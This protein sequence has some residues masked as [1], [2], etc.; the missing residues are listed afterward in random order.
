[1][2]RVAAIEEPD[3]SATVPP[4]LPT[5]V[6]EQRG[7]IRSVDR[8]LTLLEAI[9]EAGGETTLSRLAAGTKLN[10][11]TCHHLL[12]TLVKWGYVA[13]VPGRRSYA[14]G[15]RILY[16]GH[17]CVRQIDLPH[18]ARPFLERI[19]E[20]SGETVHLAVLQRDDVVTLVKRDARH[21]VRV[22]TDPHGQCYAAHASALGKSMLAW[23]PENEIRRILT[24]KGMRQFTPTTITEIPALIE[25][26]RLVRRNGFAIDREEFHPGVIC[27]AAAIRDH[28]GAV[29]GSI[30]VSTPTM[31]A[32]DTH[33]ANIR[34]H[35][36]E[37]TR[38]L[39]ADLGDPGSQPAAI[40]AVT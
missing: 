35:V 1:V 21:A 31:R 4:S 15:T 2:S 9:A 33:L 12:A 17:A 11:S 24:V 5:P 37:A 3:L 7:S 27:I 13:K 29:V 6:P 39:S 30:C 20:A 19:N 22:D 26:L 38:T 16:L 10:I 36:V 28:S 34:A 8:A 23:L 40:A 32:T 25:E 18:R 14:L